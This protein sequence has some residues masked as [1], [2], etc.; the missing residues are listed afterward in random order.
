[1]NS[2]ILVDP[3]TLSK[4]YAI[5]LEINKPHYVEQQKKQRKLSSVDDQD[6]LQCTQRKTPMC[7]RQLNIVIIK[8]LSWKVSE[9]QLEKA[10]SRYGNVNIAYILETHNSQ[11]SGIALIEFIENSVLQKFIRDKGQ[12]VSNINPNGSVQILQKKNKINEYIN[13]LNEYYGHWSDSGEQLNR[14]LL[15]IYEYYNITPQHPLL[16]MKIQNRYMSLPL[17]IE[18]LLN[19]SMQLT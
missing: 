10:A 2:S 9:I 16:A 17:A 3:N 11:S 14:L 18:T 5:D 4:I 19:Q 15:L 12:C 8:N 1:M 6:L 7:L 13:S